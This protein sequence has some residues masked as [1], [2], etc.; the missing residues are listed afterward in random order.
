MKKIL[1]LILSFFILAAS[2]CG[3]EE[4]HPSSAGDE[5]VLNLYSWADNFSPEV[6]ADFEDKYHCKI[7]YDVFGSNEELL[8]KIHA[9]GSR[10]DLIQPSDYMVSTMIKLD[11]LE[12]LDKNNIPNTAYILPQLKSPPYDPTGDYSVVYTWGVTGIAYN[13]KYIKEKPVSW[14]DLWNKK[15]KDRVI[16]L[17]DGREVIGMALKRRGYS[18]NSVNKKEIDEALQD[19]RDLRPNILAYDT[20]TIKQKFIAEEAW[21]GTMWSGD[22][23]FSYQENPDIAFVIPE[24]GA[25]IWAD[26][27]AIPK[28][29]QNKELAEKFINY[30]YDPEVSAKNYE[31]IGYNDPNTRSAPFHSE[32]YKSDPM[33]KAAKDYIS[34][35]EWIEDLGD[36]L[37]MYDRAWTEL[38]IR[39]YSFF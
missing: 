25:V 17:N 39:K 1:I 21:I 22:A 16:L 34:K 31:Y 20:D 14:T 12:K 36:A 35:G 2:G 4:S 24:E 32:E 33:L 30:L 7:N 9:G 28:G 37:T 29:A 26:T 23:S 19:L 11:L 38:K 6:L 13:T 5:Q 10:Y 8:A 3:K 15:Y 27:F 18:V